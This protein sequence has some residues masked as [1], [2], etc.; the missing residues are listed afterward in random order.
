MTDTDLTVDP[1]MPPEPAT[2]VFA[3]P[4]GALLEEIGG[5]LDSVD[6]VQEYLDRV[7]HAVRRHVTGC[8]EVGITLLLDNRPST[9][10]Y[11]TV[12]TLEIDSVQ[13]QLDEGPCL[14][15]ARLRREFVASFAEPD[16]RWPRFS[17]AVRR[18][19]VQSC[20]ALPLISGEQCVGALNLYG[21]EPR[22]FDAFEASV[23]RLAAGRA[24]DAVVAVVRLDGA[25]RLAGQLEQA[26]ASRAVIEQA[27]GVLMAVRGIDERSAFDWLR[28]TSQNHNVKLRS[29]AENV[30]AGVSTVTS[31]KSSTG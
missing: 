28:Q 19:G 31:E 4:H 24:A 9:A 3:D 23:A 5:V 21:N 25:Q 15:A 18:D 7:V 12:T 16:D 27:K 13:Y 2:E 6:E 11:T 14:D 26:M 10:A 20:L 22:A 17:A 29:L 8:D 1:A 30:V